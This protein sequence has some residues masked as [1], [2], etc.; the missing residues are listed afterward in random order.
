MEAKYIYTELAENSNKFWNVEQKGNEVTTTWGRVSDKDKTQSKT[1]TFPDEFAAQKFFESKCAEKERKGYTIQHT[2]GAAPQKASGN[3]GAIARKQIEHNG[4]SETAKLI[5]FLVKRNIHAIEGSTNI[6]F[7]STTGQFTTPLGVVTTKGIDKADGLLTDIAAHV[8]AGSG[9]SDHFTSLVNQYM[10]IIPMDIGRKRITAQDVFPN[11]AAIQQQKQL[12]DTLRTVVAD[13]EQKAADSLPTVFRTKL[14]LV[15]STDSEFKRINEKFKKTSNTHHTSAGLRL[16]K[17]WKVEVLGADEAFE[18][19]GAKVG[20]VR[21]LWHGTKDSN[22]LSLLKSGYVIPRSGSSMSITGRMYGDGVYFSDQSTKSL[23]YAT[24]YW[25][26]KSTRSFMLLNDVAMGKGFEPTGAF[27]G[28]C[29][30][31]YDSTFAKPRVSGVLNNE[32]IV[33]RTSQIRP[34]YLCEFA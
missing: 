8:E 18:K 27:S 34:K 9:Y 32:M 14:T 6:T 3:L 2:I 11:V 22:L 1:K 24:G 33:Y 21:E 4:D 19:D 16:Q 15:P 20:N 12:L 30:P 5:D 26:G 23:N 31:G 10:R 7:N 17:V 25:G 13:A 29:K 28:G